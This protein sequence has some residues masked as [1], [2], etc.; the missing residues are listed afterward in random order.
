MPEKYKRKP[1]TLCFVC[2]IPIYRRPVEIS[3][4]EG[5][6]FCSMSCYGLSSRKEGPCAVCGKLMLASL[7]KKTCSRSCSNKYRIGIKYKL[8]RPK[9]VARTFR[10]LKLRL[11]EERGKKCERC[12]YNKHEILQVHHKNRK[13]TDNNVENLE[14]ICPN[15]HYEEH[16][17]KKFIKK[18][19]LEK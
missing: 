17:L 16:L 19:N 7:N 14:I 9:D 6:V 13:R 11:F 5:R 10:I 3:K 18:I 4:N 2:K 12:G 8:G 15:C 1:N